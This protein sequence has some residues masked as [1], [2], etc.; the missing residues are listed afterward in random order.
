MDGEPSRLFILI[1]S[2]KKTSELHVQLLAAVGA[3]LGDEA[4]R[5]AVINAK[6]PEEAVKLLTKSK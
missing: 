3:I 5:E 4:L 6:T 1:V 2:P